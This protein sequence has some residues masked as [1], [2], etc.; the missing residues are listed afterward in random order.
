MGHSTLLFEY[1]ITNDEKI[2][3]IMGSI[4]KSY[5]SSSKMDLINSNKADDDKSQEGSK[6]SYITGK[7]EASKSLP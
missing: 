5:K 1:G 6:S 2:H 7:E 3:T 4:N